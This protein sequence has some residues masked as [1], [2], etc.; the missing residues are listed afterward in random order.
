MSQAAGAAG[1]E[2]QPDT[3][4]TDFPGEA[5]NVRVK[6]TIRPASQA[7]GSRRLWA[8]MNESMDLSTHLLEQFIG[9][10]L[11][12]LTAN[13]GTHIDRFVARMMVYLAKQQVAGIQ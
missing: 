3:P 4:M 5:P 1:G 8:V 6:V 11:P 7:M 12:L 2:S 9:I 10:F 13:D